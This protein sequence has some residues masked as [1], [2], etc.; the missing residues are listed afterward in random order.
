MRQDKKIE[1]LPLGG[2]FFYRKIRQKS[3]VLPVKSFLKPVIMV[4]VED[5]RVEIYL[6]DAII[7]NFLLDGALLYLALSAARQEI[8]W[9]RL[10]LGGL[11][12]AVFAVA[13]PLLPFPPW[14]TYACKLL[15]GG[16]L[17]FIALKRQK[18]RGRYALTLALF[19]GLSF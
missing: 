4:G 8:V 14:L 17:V 10:L 13:F 9:W 19:Y 15:A 5:G 11:A 18:H 1:K 7:E 6:E 16:L 3:T 12:G 2:S